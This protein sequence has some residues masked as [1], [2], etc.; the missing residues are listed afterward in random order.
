MK[1]CGS[2]FSLLHPTLLRS[3]PFFSAQ[4]AAFWYPTKR[5]HLSAAAASR[6][7]SSRLVPASSLHRSRI[8]QIHRI[9]TPPYPRPQ[10]ECSP[11]HPSPATCSPPCLSSAAYSSPRT[12]RVLRRLARTVTTTPMAK[13][14]NQSLDGKNHGPAKMSRPKRYKSLYM[15]VHRK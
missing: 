2:S 12:D 5:L 10:S 15:C 7:A 1:S 9:L 11:P 4:R 8:T 3:T 6:V 14:R 13:P